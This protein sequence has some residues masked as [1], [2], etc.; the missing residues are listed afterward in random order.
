MEERPTPTE[1]LHWYDVTIA[2]KQFHI[3][4]RYGEGHI[5]KLE[6]LLEDTL[7]E[8]GEQ[9]EGK[10]LLSVALLA[11]LNLADRLLAA[12]SDRETEVRELDDRLQELLGSLD[13][14]LGPRQEAA[15]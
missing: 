13:R 9:A 3:S 4:S 12:Q 2:G 15:V 7:G 10:T 1:S 11:A 5:R 6:R 8:M 14:V